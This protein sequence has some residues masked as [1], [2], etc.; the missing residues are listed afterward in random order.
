MGFNDPRCK[1]EKKRI[2]HK[3]FNLYRTNGTKAV[4]VEK[5][6]EC[7]GKERLMGNKD[8]LRDCVKAC[9]NSS[10]MILYGTNEFGTIRCHEKGAKG[11]KCWCED[12]TAFVCKKRIANKG[13][14]LFRYN[15]KK[16]EFSLVA[17]G[18]ECNGAERRIGYLPTLES[19]AKACEGSSDM[20][21]YGTNEFKDPRCKDGKGCVCW[22]EDASTRGC[23]KRIVHKGFNL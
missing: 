12:A 4:L 21:I 3:G 5:A 23:K 19:C 22:C 13:F 17:K 10:D 18:H 16:R 14:N 20:F 6:Q 11:C 9:G 15:D 8:T 2:V 7:N 1:D